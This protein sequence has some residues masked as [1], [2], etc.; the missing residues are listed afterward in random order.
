MVSLSFQVLLY[1]LFSEQFANRREIAF[2]CAIESS[3]RSDTNSG[4]RGPGSRPIVRR[5]A[6]RF[7]FDTISWEFPRE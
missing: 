4:Q 6:L 1:C 3:S 7:G 2:Q 5:F